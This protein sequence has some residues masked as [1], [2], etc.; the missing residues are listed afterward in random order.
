[1]NLNKSIKLLLLFLIVLAA[2]SVAATD[3]YKSYALP[4][5]GEPYLKIITGDR[6]MTFTLYDGDDEQI[7]VIRKSDVRLQVNDIYLGD[8][9]ILDPN[10]FRSG[11]RN[12]PLEVTT[13]PKS[14]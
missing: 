11:D 9:L 8:S 5:D 10:S 4:A 6:T 1:M 12:F 2:A 13:G 14:L 7:T 3:G